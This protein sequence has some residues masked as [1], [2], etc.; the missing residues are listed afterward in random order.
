MTDES[1]IGAGPRAPWRICRGCGEPFDHGRVQNFC[2][3]CVGRGADGLIEMTKSSGLGREQLAL[4]VLLAIDQVHV[5]GMKPSGHSMEMLA[6]ELFYLAEPVGT[7]RAIDGSHI[8]WGSLPEEHRD[9][10]RD[11]AKS[12]L[13]MLSETA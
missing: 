3:P 7:G 5:E 9:F 1:V 4:A 11:K 6:V 8:G 12:F 10:W 13:A 2:E